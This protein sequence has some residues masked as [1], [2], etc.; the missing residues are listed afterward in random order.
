MHS[1]QGHVLTVDSS[2]EASFESLSGNSSL[3]TFD[4]IEEGNTKAEVVDTGTSGRF[5]V[6]T[7]G[8]ERHRD[9]TGSAAFAGNVD[10]DGLTELDDVNVTGFST[11]TDDVFTGIERLL[12][13]NSCIYPKWCRSK[14]W[15]QQCHQ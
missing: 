2:G 9:S 11:F 12:V 6:E 14:I 13:G 10:V 5:I 3:G 7:E 1:T 8:T 15:F 4:K